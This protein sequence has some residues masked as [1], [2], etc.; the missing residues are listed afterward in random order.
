MYI[1]LCRGLCISQFHAEIISIDEVGGFCLVL[2]FVGVDRLS[3]KRTHCMGRQ[4]LRGP[5]GIWGECTKVQMGG[6]F[7]VLPWGGSKIYSTFIDG[8]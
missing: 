7:I 4:C 5:S 2:V 1:Q 6:C 3:C 8:V